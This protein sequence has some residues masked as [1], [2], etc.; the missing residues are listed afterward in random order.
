MYYAMKIEKYKKK[1]N[2][3]TFKEIISFTEG[4]RLDEIEKAQE[5]GKRPYQKVL[6]AFISGLIAL[7]I[8]SWFIWLFKANIFK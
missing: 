7:L 3:Q 4:K 2:I 5:Y 8:C 1:N 6:A